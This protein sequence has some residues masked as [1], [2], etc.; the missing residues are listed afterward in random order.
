[1]HH[2]KSAI[3]MRSHQ[4]VFDDT[5]YWRFSIILC[6]IVRKN[7]SLCARLPSSTPI[8]RTSPP[9]E[10][11]CPSERQ[12]VCTAAY[13][14]AHPPHQP[15]HRLRACAQANGSLCARLLTST[16]IRRTSPPPECLCPSE[17]QLVCTAAYIHAHP[18]HQPTA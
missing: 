8:R 10:C 15:T 17:R 18:P 2:S 16:P 4:S 1:M 12:L 7:G 5:T 9:P 6:Q 3:K 13:I 11:L 14:H